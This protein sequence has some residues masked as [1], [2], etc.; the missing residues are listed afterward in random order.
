MNFQPTDLN[1]LKKAKMLLENTSIAV[2]ITNFIGIPIEEG[3]A[4][5]P[6]NCNKNIHEIT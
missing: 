6:E 1:D 5:L 4:L 3:F 2:K